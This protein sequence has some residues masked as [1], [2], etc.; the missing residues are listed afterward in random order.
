M[1]IDSLCLVY[2]KCGV[3]PTVR[4]VDFL[5]SQFIITVIQSL[6]GPAPGTHLG[7]ITVLPFHFPKGVVGG[8]GSLLSRGLKLLFQA[9]HVLSH[10]VS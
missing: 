5:L 7:D 1:Y 3:A 10:R 2:S 9:P 6:L 8:A 4:S